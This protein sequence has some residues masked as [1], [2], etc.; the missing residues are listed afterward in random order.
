MSIF[1]YIN[2]LCIAISGFFAGYGSGNFQRFINAL[3]CLLNLAIV[4]NHIATNTA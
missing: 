4:I 1:I 3:A 2:V